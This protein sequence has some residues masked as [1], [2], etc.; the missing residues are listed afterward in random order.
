MMAPAAGDRLHSTMLRARDR[1]R[2]WP[3]GQLSLMFI[4][5]ILSFVVYGL[6]RI[7]YFTV[8]AVFPVLANIIPI[9]GPIVS[10][11]FG[12]IVASFD[13]WTKVL[14]V[15]IF[16][17]IYQQLENALLTPRIMKTTVGLPSLAVIV[18]LAI[19]GELGGIL[20]AMVAV[21]SAAILSE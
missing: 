8:L 7:R 13:S 10:I 17:A 11:T 3:A 16:Y 2:R 18:A 14:G 15:L 4:L 9:I 1:L 21:P 20:G 6:L 19:A 12:V 5:G